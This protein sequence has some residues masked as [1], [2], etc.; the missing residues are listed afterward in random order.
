MLMRDQTIPIQR[1]AGAGLRVLAVMILVGGVLISATYWVIDWQTPPLPWPLAAVI[2]LQILFAVA[3]ASWFWLL[4]RRA[5]MLGTLVA[6]DYPVLTCT[7]LCARL[8]GELIAILFVLSSLAFSIASL[9]AADPAAEA[10]LTWLDLRAGVVEP[11][12]YGLAVVTALL[13]PIAGLA[14]GGFV[15]FGAYLFAEVL[16]AKLEFWRDIRRIREQLQSGIP[17]SNERDAST[18]TEET[19]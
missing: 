13:W 2:L 17:S 6:H 19:S 11:A 10:A 8:L 18:H 4:W 3:I 14:A 15:L 1:L 12:T 9:V 16:I 7:A 5:G